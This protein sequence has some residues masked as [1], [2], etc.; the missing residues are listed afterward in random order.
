MCT[1]SCHTP[2]GDVGSEL[3]ID[4]GHRGFLAYCLE[5]LSYFTGS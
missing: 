1:A 2:H 5:E 4:L 3:L